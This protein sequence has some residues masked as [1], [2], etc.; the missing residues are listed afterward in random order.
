MF[1]ISRRVI[2]IQNVLI[3]A[4]LFVI[5]R[6]RYTALDVYIRYLSPVVFDYSFL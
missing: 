4:F 6:L 1:F 2:V 5:V 3:C